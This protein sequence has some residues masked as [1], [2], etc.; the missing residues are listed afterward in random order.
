MQAQGMP[1]NFGPGSGGGGAYAANTGGG[2]Q[3]SIAKSETL[4]ML[5]KLQHGSGNTNAVLEA[6]GKPDGS[7]AETIKRELLQ[8]AKQ[9]GVTQGDEQGMLEPADETAVQLAGNMFEVMLKDRPY[10][11]AVAPVLAQMVMPFVRAA[12]TDPQLFLERHHPARELLNTVS[13]ACED[14]LGET[15]QE[16]E[17]LSQVENAVQRISEEYD[18]DISKFQSVQAQLSSQMEV[19]RRRAQMSEKRATEAQQGQER[20]EIARLQAT[21][22]VNNI[23]RQYALPSAL[24]HFFK[25]EWMHHLSV[26]ALRKG[27]DS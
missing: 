14:N 22:V 3:R 2:P 15:P 5:D 13:E 24:R 9:M 18:G 19:H 23:V 16:R 17:M 21:T 20:L 27:K 8:N 7:I 10:G 4:A 6:I 26:T 25:T 1:T 11:D 12:V